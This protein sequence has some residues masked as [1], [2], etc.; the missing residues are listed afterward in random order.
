VPRPGARLSAAAAIAG[1]AIVNAE[2]LSGASV[3]YADEARLRRMDRFGRAGFLAGSAALVD[4]RIAR[5]RE[6][7]PRVGLVVG[8]AFGCRDAVTRHAHLLA[9][10]AHTDELSPSLF[11]QTVHNTVAGERALAWGGGGIPTWQRRGA[12]SAGA[13]ARAARSFHAPPAGRGSSS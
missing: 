1:A 6:P 12:P 4:A 13:T 5:T 3:P 7:A 11:T 10:T 8:T 2:N 9:E